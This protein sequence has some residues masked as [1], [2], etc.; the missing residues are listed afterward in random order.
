MLNNALFYFLPNIWHSGI[1][2]DFAKWNV[3]QALPNL[4]KFIKF[5]KK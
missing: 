2:D 4:E 5:G 3:L 1:F